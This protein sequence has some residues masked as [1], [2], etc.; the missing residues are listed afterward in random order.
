MVA[1]PGKDVTSTGF[2]MQGWC[3]LPPSLWEFLPVLT[4]IPGPV[5]TRHTL[6][7]QNQPPPATF[8]LPASPEGTRSHVL[9]LDVGLTCDTSG[10]FPLPNTHPPD[11]RPQTLPVLH[12]HYLSIVLSMPRAPGKAH[13]DAS[14]ASHGSQPVPAQWAEGIQRGKEAEA[15]DQWGAEHHLHS[16]WAELC[17]RGMVPRG[18]PQSHLEGERARAGNGPGCAAGQGQERGAQAVGAQLLPAPLPA[19]LPAH[20]LPRGGWEVFL[21][22]ANPFLCEC[23]SA[24]WKENNPSGAS[25]GVRSSPSPFSCPRQALVLFPG[26]LAQEIKAKASL[27]G[28]LA[29]SST[30]HSH[31]PVLV[32]GTDSPS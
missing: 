23:C 5:R 14:H 7:L 10:S 1:L 21:C 24:A 13:R 31:F 3:P 29:G 25:P 16:P 27:A 19:P 2:Q 32:S 30:S 18:S 22:I 8:T 20:T 4:G 17:P 28:S 6:S 11:H 12:V 26:C 15:P 9:P